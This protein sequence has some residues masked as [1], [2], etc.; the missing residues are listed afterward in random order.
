MI[1]LLQQV[2][3]WCCMPAADWVIPWSP[4]N[5]LNGTS[6]CTLH[7]HWKR[8]HANIHPEGIYAR[9]CSY[10]DVLKR[11]TKAGYLPPQMQY[12]AQWR[13]TQ[14][15]FSGVYCV[16]V[17]GFGSLDTSKYLT[18]GDW[19]QCFIPTT[20]AM[21][22]MACSCLKNNN[23]AGYVV[24]RVKELPRQYHRKK[25][26]S[27]AGYGDLVY[28]TSGLC[29]ISNKIPYEAAHS[30]FICTLAA[31]TVNALSLIIPF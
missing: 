17:T 23:P 28:V 7:C 22:R 4:A 13:W 10:D 20:T 15:Y 25:R 24:A 14:W 12:Y 2:S 26:N 27:H 5:L 9:G 18:A 31:A 8:Q 1:P 6:G 16:A 11:W 21:A 19:L 29:V 30:C 3:R